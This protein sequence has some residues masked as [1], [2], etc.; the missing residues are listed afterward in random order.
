MVMVSELSLAGLVALVNGWGTV[1]R[2]EAGEQDLAFPDLEELAELLGP[3]TAGPLRHAAIVALADQL[4]PVFAAAT[5]AQRVRRTALLLKESG[6]RPTLTAAPDGIRAVWT[7][8]HVGT[9]LLAAAA[10]TLRQHLEDHDGERL[11]I[12]T[13]IRCADVYVD[14]S[15]VGHRRYCS[16]AC[17]NRTRVAAFRQARRTTSRRR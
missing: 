1:P 4:Y 6:V 15:P 11:G 5:P 12:C 3:W 8:D 9:A 10:V 13:A 2:T 7:V 16:I 17:Q 14:A